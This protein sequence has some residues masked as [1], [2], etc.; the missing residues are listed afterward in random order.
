M[1]SYES[2]TLKAAESHRGLST[3]ANAHA[4]QKK[5]QKKTWELFVYPNQMSTSN[6]DVPGLFL[7]HT[8]S[9]EVSYLTGNL[10]ETF[11][12]RER[13]NEGRGRLTQ[14]CFFFWKC[15]SKWRTNGGSRKKSRASKKGAWFRMYEG[16]IPTI[17]THQE[18]TERDRRVI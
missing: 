16:E 6:R 15:G 14:G 18:M 12:S 4:E 3:L 2:T 17:I 13:K 11:R 1:K 7:I 10:K 8:T 5:K 9:C